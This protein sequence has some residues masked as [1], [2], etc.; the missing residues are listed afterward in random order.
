MFFSEIHPVD[1][2]KSFYGKALE[3]ADADGIHLL[4]YGTNVANISNDG[5]CTVN[6]LHSATTTR[7]IKAFLSCHGFEY[8]DTEDILKR[9][10]KA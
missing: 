2:R 9:Y 6:S 8:K 5:K 10:S 4:S 3:Y 1:G 7:H